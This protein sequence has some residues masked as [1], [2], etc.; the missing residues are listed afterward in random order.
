MNFMILLI[1]QQCVIFQKKKVHWPEFK[2]IYILNYS[3]FIKLWIIFKW[4]HFLMCSKC[5][6]DLKSKVFIIIKTR[7][8]ILNKTIFFF[9]NFQ[10][11]ELSILQINLNFYYGKIS[12]F[13]NGKRCFLTLAY[14]KVKFSNINFSSLEFL[15]KFYGH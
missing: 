3:I 5:I 11:W 14:M 6:N 7:F 4:F 12:Y 1:I 15:L 9:K 2:R 13:E 10:I 8:F